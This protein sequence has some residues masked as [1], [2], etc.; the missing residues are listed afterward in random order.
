[1]VH[2]YYFIQFLLSHCKTNS[3]V[4]TGDMWAMVPRIWACPQVAPLTYT[5]SL[6]PH[7]YVGPKPHFLS[8]RNA[9]EN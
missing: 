1:M 6:C 9:N 8:A 2:G 3:V 7:I 4:S 5:S